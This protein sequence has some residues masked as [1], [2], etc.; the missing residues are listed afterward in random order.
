MK[1]AQWY[2]AGLVLVL[3]GLGYGAYR[4]VQ[5]VDARYA[6]YDAQITNLETELQAALKQNEE[7]GGTLAAEKERNDAF[8]NQIEDI[9]GTVGT[10][11]KLAKT[12]PELLAKYSKI[13]FLNENYVPSGLTTIDPAFT[14]NPDKPYEFHRDAYPFLEELLEDAQDDGIDLKVVSAFRSFGT[15]A[16]LKASYTTRFGS[17]ANTFSADQGYSEHQLGTTVD[18]TTEEIGSSFV[19]FESTPAYAWLTEN[20]HRYGF[21]LSYPENNT[22]YIY[23]PWHWRFVGE[24]LARDLH[25]DEVHFYDLDQRKLDEYLVTLFD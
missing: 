13:Y 11:E 17:G 10:L 16:G 1:A 5:E 14:L 18:F 15:Q 24:D 6:A 23:E 22:Y 19:G 20:A 12:D 3:I 21:V 8:E 9:T 25:R 2:T 4:Y 7:L